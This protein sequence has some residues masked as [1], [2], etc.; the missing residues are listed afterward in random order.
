ME[1][2][3]FN[4]DLSDLKSFLFNARLASYASNKEPQAVDG[5]KKF[6]FS[7][8]KHPKLLYCDSYVGSV[9]F[10]GQ[11]IIFYNP[12][13][14]KEAH[15]DYNPIW[16]MIYSGFVFPHLE[17]SEQEDIFQYLRD[18]L[19]QIK[20]NLIPRR[21]PECLPG[22]DYIYKNHFFGGKKGDM[23]NFSGKEKIFSRDISGLE[24]EVVYQCEYE[25]GWLHNYF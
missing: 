24:G 6:T 7:E 9:R 8:D 21:G 15:N 14:T 23:Y 17:E 25:G 2:T 16:S 13:K 12:N 11:E 5:I 22:K 3:L 1:N 20:P 10:L 18:A 19:R 4:E